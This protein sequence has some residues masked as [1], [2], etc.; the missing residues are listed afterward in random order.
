MSQLFPADP[1]I[2]LYDPLADLLGAG[3]GYFH[4]VFD[5]AVKLSGHAC[6]TVAG[7][8]LMT[9]QALQA[10]YG[11]QTPTRGEIRVTIPGPADEGVNGPISQV[12]TLLTGAAGDNGF[13]GLGGQH[14]RNGL[15]NFIRDEEGFRFQRVDNREQV[16]VSYDPSVIP[17]DPAMGPLMQQL[18]QGGA[19]EETRQCFRQLWRARVL[20]IL[21]DAGRHTVTVR[22]R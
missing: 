5:D 14:A 21:K 8:F 13:Q 11:D 19:G 15:L 1:S 12:F 17:P 16:A 10:L 4:Y 9:L 18:L 2:T 6:P 3:D 22:Q 7:A 20:A